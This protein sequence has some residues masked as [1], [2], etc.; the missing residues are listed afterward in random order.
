[1][2]SQAIYW[3]ILFFNKTD[4]HTEQ[5]AVKFVINISNTVRNITGEDKCLALKQLKDPFI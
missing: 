1:M 4:M 3:T 2:S 5:F